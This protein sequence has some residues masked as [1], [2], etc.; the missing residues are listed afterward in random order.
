MAIE[1]RVWTTKE[2]AQ[3]QSINWTK[4]NTDPSSLSYWNPQGLCIG[5]KRNQMKT[6]FKPCGNEIKGSHSNTQRISKEEFS[7]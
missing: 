7:F 1:N 6:R 3:K 5:G 4:E 2:Q